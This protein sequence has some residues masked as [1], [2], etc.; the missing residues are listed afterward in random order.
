LLLSAPPTTKTNTLLFFWSETK[1]QTKDLYSL[2][3]YVCKCI[4]LLP[5]LRKW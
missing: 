3:H 2:L 4:F 1:V 5:I